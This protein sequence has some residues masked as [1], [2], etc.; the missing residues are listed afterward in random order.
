MK[1]IEF[2]AGPRDLGNITAVQTNN[3][4]LFIY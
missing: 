1:V 3:P 4:Y 2:N